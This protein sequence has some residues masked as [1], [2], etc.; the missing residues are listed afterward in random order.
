M[1]TN[2]KNAYLRRWNSQNM[3]SSFCASLPLGQH[4]AILTKSYYAALTKRLEHLDLERYFS[5]LILIECMEEKGCT[6]QFICDHLKIDKVSMVRILH[7][8]QEKHYIRKVVNPTD[9]REY[10]VEL[11]EKA[12]QI[13][14]EIHQAIKE[15]NEAA[16]KGLAKIQ[17]KEFHQVLT[18]IQENLA[19]L[20]SEKI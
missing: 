16:F 13:L 11:S 4:L 15:V 18:G 2:C 8:L 20:P 6:Q 14:P 12:R 7:Y 9:R 19:Q 10:F 5:V 17:Q 3:E 1:R